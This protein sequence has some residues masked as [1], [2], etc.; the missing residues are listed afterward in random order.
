[1]ARFAQLLQQTPIREWPEAQATGLRDDLR[2]APLFV[3]DN[4]WEYILAQGY[5]RLSITPPPFPK[6]WME[7]HWL[8]RSHLGAFLIERHAPHWHMDSY[9][10]SGNEQKGRADFLAVHRT[11]LDGRDK[12]EELVSHP[13]PGWSEDDFLEFLRYATSPFVLAMMF[14]HCK[15]VARVEH[16]PPPKLAKRN[17]ERG[18]PFMLK[19]Q[20]LEIE[21]FK[22]ILKTEGKIES[23]GLERAL[24]ICRGHFAHY[25]E[26]GKGLFGR[27]Q[28]GDFWIPAHARGT[29]KKGVVVSDYEVNAPKEPVGDA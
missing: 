18:K 22:Q 13:R 14:M 5:G 29:E 17:L 4:I 28:Y 27:G 8:G 24:H 16:T 12:P 3:I 7:F 23:V 11:H 6:L 21:P 10:F 20:T 19:Y 1:M 25:D 26:N 15:N 2:R 9:L